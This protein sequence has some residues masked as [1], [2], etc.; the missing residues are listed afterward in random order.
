MLIG[1]SNGAI[2]NCTKWVIIA[3]ACHSKASLGE[4]AVCPCLP[5]QADTAAAGAKAKKP[6]KRAAVADKQIHVS[7]PS[8]FPGQSSLALAFAT[9]VATSA[10][11]ESNMRPQHGHRSCTS[12]KLMDSLA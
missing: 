10:R 5:V 11:R 12:M 7:R 8:L 4:A 3:S 2:G 9:A 6:I 1:W